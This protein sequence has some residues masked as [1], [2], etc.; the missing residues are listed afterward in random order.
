VAERLRRQ[1]ALS[2]DATLNELA[3]RMGCLATYV[4]VHRAL[5]RMELPYKKRRS[6]PQSKTEAT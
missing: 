1:V 6:G 2:P 3:E 4:T 5:E